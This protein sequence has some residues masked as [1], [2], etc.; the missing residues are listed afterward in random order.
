M[1]VDTKDFRK[2]KNIGEGC[3]FYGSLLSFVKKLYY[4]SDNQV[5]ELCGTDVVLYLI[6][7]KYSAFLFG[8]SKSF[9]LQVSLISILVMLPMYL[10]GDN[11]QGYT[12]LQ[13]LTVLNN[14]QNYYLMW[15][16]FFF[17]IVYS[18]FGHILLHLLDEKRRQFSM[19]QSEDTDVM[20]ESHLAKHSV[21][22]RGIN[23][24]LGPEHV[25]KIMREVLMKEYPDMIA[26]CHAL[27]K[28]QKLNHMLI[29]H[30][31]CILKTDF[32]IQEHQ[33]DGGRTYMRKEKTYCGTKE[34][35]IPN[36]WH[37]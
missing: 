25:E 12:I 15:I 2:V 24:D 23:P 17:T 33:R 13:R 16:V 14:L 32:Y 22:I 10:S 19:M 29:K 7:L 31:R 36:Y 26:D 6:V 37:Y 1:H 5:R 28:F 21:M 3:A 18:M 20:N 27:G 30:N 9:S 11:A 4:A 8:A 34:T 35:S